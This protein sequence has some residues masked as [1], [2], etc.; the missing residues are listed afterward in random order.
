[1]SKAILLT[2]WDDGAWLVID[3]AGA[4]LAR[5]GA[6]VTALHPSSSRAPAP[7]GSSP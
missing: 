4:T 7:T 5:K 6:S 1:M 3:R 2:V